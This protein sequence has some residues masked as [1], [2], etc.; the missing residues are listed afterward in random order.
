MK[1]TAL[2]TFM[3]SLVSASSNAVGF[4]VSFS[5]IAKKLGPRPAVPGSRVTEADLME[6]IGSKE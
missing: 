5:G 6:R 4:S 1:R 2:L 3:R